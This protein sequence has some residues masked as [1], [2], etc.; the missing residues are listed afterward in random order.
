MSL[1]PSVQ[2]RIY[3]DD[4]DAYG[5]VNQAAFLR[6]FERA[7]WEALAAGPGTD[8]FTRA[9]A[10]PAIRRASVEYYAAAFPGEALRFDLSLTHHGKT[11]FSMHQLVRRISDGILI[12][13]GDFT[14]ICIDA[15]GRPTDIPAAV[16]D[17]FGVRPPIPGES[18]RH[19]TIGER[20]LTVEVQGDGLSIL[21]IHGFPMDRTLWRPLMAGL[22]GWRRLAPD[23]PGFGL[24]DPFPDGRATIARYADDLVRVLDEFRVDRAV[25]WG[26][27]LGGYIAFEIWRKHRDRVRA[28]VLMSTRA[29]ADK[30]DAIAKRDEMIAD[31]GANGT[32]ALAETFFPRLLA[33][34]TLS[35][36]GPVAA[37]V[38]T[39]L[40]DNQPAGLQAA[41]AA[42]RDREDSTELLAS[43]T[44]P[45]LVVAGQEDVLIPGGTSRALARGIKGSRFET[46]TGA[47]HVAPL[48]QPEATVKVV[49][50]FLGSLM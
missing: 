10:W 40:L 21:M 37:H 36:R 48:E 25:V 15:K 13:A 32:G 19:I 23:L 4:C 34:A 29:E 38:R 26:L 44:V 43:V 7:R 16:T 17:M 14:A 11:S 12:A 8:V 31:I 3:P 2:L 39:M 47:G 45:T 22:A 9:G 24:S 18:P 20:Q 35:D 1:V 42:M 41:V 46:I 5:H 50:D 6:M 33:P 49:A 27:S 28:F 30:P